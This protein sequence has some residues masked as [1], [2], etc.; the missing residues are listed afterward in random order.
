MG[1]WALWKWFQ[2]WSKIGYPN[3]IYWY[4]EYFLKTPEQRAAEKRIREYE[5]AKLFG[6][7]SEMRRF[8]HSRGFHVS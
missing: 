5:A 4:S 1:F 8:S 6:L 7:L 2:S 3:M